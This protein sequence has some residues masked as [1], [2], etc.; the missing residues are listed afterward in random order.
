MDSYINPKVGNDLWPGTSRPEDI[1][2][3]V[4][5]TPSELVPTITAE[6]QGAKQMKITGQSP[7]K[8]MRS[9]WQNLLNSAKALTTRTYQFLCNLTPPIAQSVAKP[10]A[11]EDESDYV[12]AFS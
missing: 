1:V 11:D 10:T 2:V 8:T 5:N 4:E 6:K 7:P 9:Q 12:S 3:I